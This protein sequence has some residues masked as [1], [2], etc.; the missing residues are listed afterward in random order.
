MIKNLLRLGFLISIT[1][2]T[3]GQEFIRE[4]ILK[5]SEVSADKNYGRTEKKSIK[6][7]KIENQKYYLNALLGP[8]EEPIQYRRVGSCCEF[9]SKS[10][11]FGKGFLDVY[12]VTYSGLQA[13]IKLYLNGYD[14]ETP[15]CPSG[16]TFKKVDGVREIIILQ[17][18]LS[19]SIFCNKESVYSVDDYLLKGKVGQFKTADINPKYPGG[20]DKLK[21]YFSNN[22]LTD[23]RAN[24]IVFRVS[25]G[26]LVNCKGETGNFQIVTEGKGDLRELAQQVLEK[27]KAM[28]DKWIAATTNSGS[29]DSYQILSFTV[30]NGTLDKVSYRE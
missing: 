30:T 21:T 13:P 14:Y 22:N 3:Y 8:N 29:V 5:V 26:F 27:A 2:L 15:L 4:D 18:T 10:A 16:L 23:K 7:G 19:D 11:A 24:G 6:V 20:I 12:E 17:P 25:I 1:H 28:P 9:R